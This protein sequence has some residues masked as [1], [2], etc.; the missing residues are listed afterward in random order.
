MRVPWTARRPWFNSWVGKIHWRRDRLPIPIFLGFPGGSAGKESA[1]NARDLGSF[2]GLERSP[3]ERNGYPLNYSTLESSM[4][5]IVNCYCDVLRQ[6]LY[7]VIFSFSPSGC[8]FGGKKCWSPKKK[9][10][11]QLST[12]VSALIAGIAIP[13]MITGIPVYQ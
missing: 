10:P 12:L 6:L 11:W 3:G 8:T 1:C 5:C 7:I 4:D 2:P 13:D 9:I